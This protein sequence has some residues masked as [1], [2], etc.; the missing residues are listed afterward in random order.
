VSS[1]FADAVLATACLA[2]ALRDGLQAVRRTDRQRISCQDGRFLTGSVDVDQATLAN[3]PQNNRWDYG[4]GVRNDDERVVWVEIHPASSQ[5]V[6]EV[7]AKLH[8]LRGWLKSEAPLL[9]QFPSRF[10]WVASG[11]VALTPNS[12]Q[13]RRVAQEGIYFAGERVQVDTL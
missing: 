8:W 7:I 10:V 3:H 4:I 13:R 9:R 6:L 2:E 12:P 11:K 5:H 1:A